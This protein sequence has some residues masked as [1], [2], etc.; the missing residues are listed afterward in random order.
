MKK[1]DLFISEKLKGIMT[2]SSINIPHKIKIQLE[3]TEH[4]FVIKFLELKNKI[5]EAV[6]QIF[7]PLY[8]KFPDIY[9]INYTLVKIINIIELTTL[10][11]TMVNPKTSFTFNLTIKNIEIL[12][13]IFNKKINFETLNSINRKL[14]NLINL[15]IKYLIG[16]FLYLFTLLRDCLDPKKNENTTIEEILFKSYIAGKAY[17][18]KYI[19]ELKKNSK[20]KQG[21]KKIV[22]EK[23]DRL[24]IIKNNNLSD[25]DEDEN[26]DATR[27]KYYINNSYNNNNEFNEVN[28]NN[29]FENY[30]VNSFD[31]LINEFKLRTS[32]N[33]EESII[34]FFKIVSIDSNKFNI[35]FKQSDTKSISLNLK[36]VNE[37]EKR[38]IGHRTSFGI[39]KYIPS[40]GNISANVPRKNQMNIFNTNKYK[41]DI[42]KI[43]N[44][45]NENFTNSTKNTSDK[46]TLDEIKNNN[47][48]NNDLLETP[49]FCFK[50]NQ[51]LNNSQND[52]LSLNEVQKLIE[53]C[54]KHHSFLQPYETFNIFFN[55][56]EIIHR[57]FFE[58]FFEE[59]IGKIFYY[60]KDKD[61]LIKLESLYNF[62][63]YLRGLKNILFVEK[64]RIYFSNVFFMDDD[65]D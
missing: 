16:Q 19:N 55:T 60:E 28:N 14:T 4:Y 47:Q 32:V 46:K 40:P 23:I 30:N 64:N 57:K 45:N 39:N 10:R 31:S 50:K 63:L 7:F 2:I 49:K 17:Y 6:H 3:F 43:N 44:S 11:I 65:D 12:G 29:S 34:L 33:I 37:R 26:E 13:V 20:L 53:E 27:E 59:F 36:S 41:I 5:K 62:F 51:S 18:E 25:S 58:I 15:E 1:N 38:K 9:H 8:E 56:T 54:S 21:I 35:K 22:L 48:S 61:S 52:N 42:H 24:N